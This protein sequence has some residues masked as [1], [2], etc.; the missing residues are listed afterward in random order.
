MQLINVVKLVIMSQL[1]YP[2]AIPLLFKNALQID[3]AAVQCNA[4]DMR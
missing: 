3:D 4:I 2:I 1:L